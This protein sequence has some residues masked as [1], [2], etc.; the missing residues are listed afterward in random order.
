MKS[1]KRSGRDLIALVK[2]EIDLK[3]LCNH[4]FEEDENFINGLKYYSRRVAPYVYL[5]VNKR[6]RELKVKTLMGTAA[7]I[8]SHT[9]K[10]ND[11]LVAG[12][13]EMVE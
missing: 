5:V 13:V 10:F 1:L 4:G 7:F 6:S 2:K 8:E 9:Y 12:I 11:L 3:E